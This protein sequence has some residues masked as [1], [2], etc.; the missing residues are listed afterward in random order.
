MRR[1]LA[2]TCAREQPP[3]DSE[4]CLASFER[5]A[6]F[7]CFIRNGEAVLLDDGQ[8][9]VGKSWLYSDGYKKCV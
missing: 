3:K 4:W 2:V 7:E 6:P 8:P 1:K 9:A 5:G